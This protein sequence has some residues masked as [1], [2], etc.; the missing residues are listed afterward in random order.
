M[1]R[2]RTHTEQRLIE[3]VGQIIS[4]EG[5]DRVGVNRIASRSG[6]NKILIYR[7]FGGLEGLLEAYVRQNQTLMTVPELDINRL[8]DA[9]LQESFDV[10]YHYL[11]ETYRQLSQNIEAQQL[12]K[13]NLV[14]GNAVSSQLV[15]D[16]EKALQRMVDDLS[17]AI[18]TDMGRPLAVLLMSAITLLTFMGQQKRTLL[19][20]ELGSETGRKQMEQAFKQ[21]LD[22]MLLHAQA[23]L[24]GNS[25]ET[26]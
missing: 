26:T 15:A 13:V 1:R 22:G 20:I 21:L 2:D 5:Y 8:K 16:Q 14:D 17:E 3:T 18:Q 4:Q 6:I 23:R 9:S 25:P 24:N 7:Y 12:L 11:I 10:C 19:G